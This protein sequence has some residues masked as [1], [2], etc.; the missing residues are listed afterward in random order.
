MHAYREIYFGG[1]SQG[2]EK[3]TK[4]RDL[5]QSAISV[6]LVRARQCWNIASTRDPIFEQDQTAT[7]DRPRCKRSTNEKSIFRS[8]RNGRRFFYN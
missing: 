1:R 7:S 5:V 2:N 4:S 3:L 8:V 6:R